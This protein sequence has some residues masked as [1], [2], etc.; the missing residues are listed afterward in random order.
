MTFH[1]KILK[2]KG[3]DKNGPYTNE[4]SGGSIEIIPIKEG[5]GKRNGKVS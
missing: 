5:S 2:I 1:P 4:I 3:G